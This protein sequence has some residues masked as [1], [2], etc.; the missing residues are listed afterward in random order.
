MVE[1]ISLTGG[2]ELMTA[3]SVGQHLTHSATGA[4]HI[5]IIIRTVNYPRLINSSI[6]S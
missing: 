3:I 4:P 5:Y 6:Y 2:L 1:K